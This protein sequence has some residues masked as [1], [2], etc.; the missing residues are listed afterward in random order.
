[1]P[2]RGKAKYEAPRGVR[3]SDSKNGRGNP[4]CIPLGNSDI[5][6]YNN[7]GTASYDCFV[8]NNAQACVSVGGTP[9]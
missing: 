4:G 3:L 1:M 2:K 7:G 6:C 5:G 9:S 8:G